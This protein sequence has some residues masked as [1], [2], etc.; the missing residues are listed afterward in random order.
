M[1]KNLLTL[2]LM[3]AGVAAISQVPRKTL[4]EEFTGENCGPCASTNPA[5]NVTLAG[6]PNVIA[7]KWQV[8][9]PSAP[10]ATWSLWQTNL[11]EIQWRYTGAGYGYPSQNT[12]TNSV[13]SGINSAPSGRFDGQH[14]W[15]FGATSDH[16]F[17]VSNTVINNAAAVTTPFG[18]TMTPVWDG[19][20]SNAVVS[21]T[22]AA[23]SSFTSVGALVF[24]LCLIERKINF[25]TAPG[26]NGEK[27]FEDVVRKSYPTIQS[28]TALSGTWTAGQVQTFT[29]ACAAPSYIVDK[30]QMAFVGFIQ[31]DGNK[32]V[33]QAERTA[34]PS[35]PN[36][37]KV[38]SIVATAFSCSNSINPSVAVK[39]IGSNS[40]TSLTITPYIDGVAQTVYTTAVSIASGATSTV[41]LSTYT[42]TSGSHT[43]SVNINGVSGGDVNT[44]NNTGSS[45]FA[46]VQTYF[47]GPVTEGYVSTTFP[48][49]N[50]FK[51]NA[52]GGAANWSRNSTAGVAPSGAGAAKYDFYNN[53]VIGDSD[54]L[55]L[56]PSDLTGI[57]SPSLTFD[58]AY[59]FYTAVPNNE[60][61]KLE[62]FCSTNCGATWTSIYMKAGTTLTTA[63]LTT[64][65]FVPTAL[66]WRNEVVALP[67]GASNNP[68][69]LVKFTATSDYGNNLYIDNVNLGQAT[70][71][72]VKS[73]AASEFNVEL[74]PNP[75]S[76]FTNLNVTT[77]NASSAKVLVYNTIGQLV[78]EKAVTL[79]EGFNNITID[80]KTLSNGVYNVVL[81]SSNGSIAKKL[82]VSK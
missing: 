65:A 20:F 12:S 67:A 51:T 46:L 47:P 16:P 80:T 22:V 60:S 79:N 76:E 50:W 7:L 43:F 44:A 25:P 33:M 17:Y 54:D 10:T 39:N 21:V 24:R 55:F 1:K 9:I 82:T 26:T 62:V 36:D 18:I 8:P 71:T 68:S 49:T 27:D 5:L 14:Q 40:I 2:G 57:T 19:T 48:P 34:Q 42:A 41:A 58:V 4:F 53:A 72:A 28:G 38:S 23:A 52:D 75:S 73:I 6:N 81:S 15:T 63:P 61:D 13:T 70:V 59:A 11:S 45:S 66:Q 64:A 74:F 29:I 56:P 78:S 35:I 31:D 69:V 77:K 3:I 32:K 37:A 30:S